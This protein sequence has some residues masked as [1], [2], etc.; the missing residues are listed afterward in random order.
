MPKLLMSLFAGVMLALI[1]SLNATAEAPATQPGEAR[2]RLKAP[3]FVLKLS[4]E[5]DVV[6]IGSKPAI[7]ARLENVSD[8][9]IVLVGFRPGCEY[10]VRYPKMPVMI[11]INPQPEE[12]TDTGTIGPGRGL[13]TDDFVELK[14]GESF[15]PFDAERGFSEHPYLQEELSHKGVYTFR[16]TYNVAGETL[17]EWNDTGEK[18]EPD[19]ELGQLIKR[20]PKFKVESNELKIRVVKPGK[21]LKKK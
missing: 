18:L 11:W 13:T 4:V 16:L 12:V 7:Q 19:G 1:P 10:S 14:P 3:P 6:E 5:H 20:V 17:R 21:L 2:E 8:E 15:D 9:T